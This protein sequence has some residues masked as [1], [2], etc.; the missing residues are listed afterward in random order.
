[1]ERKF[2]LLSKKSH[3]LVTTLTIKSQEKDL[4]LNSYIPFPGSSVIGKYNPSDKCF[5]LVSIGGLLYEYERSGK[6]S[7]SLFVQKLKHDD[8][9]VWTS[10]M[11]H[12][13]PNQIT[14]HSSRDHMCGSVMDELKNSCVVDMSHS[15]DLINLVGFGGERVQDGI[16]SDEIFV[17]R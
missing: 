8:N 14:S 9:S 2:W 10:E 15:P 16:S 7:S 6:F 3:Q 13:R 1:M 17:I 5:C 11:C 12:I 4:K